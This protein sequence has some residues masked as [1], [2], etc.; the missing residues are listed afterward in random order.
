VNLYR[1]KPYY[2][3]YGRRYIFG[4]KRNVTID[5]CK[6]TKQ[7]EAEA[8]DPGIPTSEQTK[9]SQGDERLMSAV[10]A[11]PPKQVQK[12]FLHFFFSLLQTSHIHQHRNHEGNEG[13]EYESNAGFAEAQT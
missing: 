5:E 9:I 10:C 4:I 11:S 6:L 2:L 1:H 7:I 8:K 3:Q 13:H 12:Q